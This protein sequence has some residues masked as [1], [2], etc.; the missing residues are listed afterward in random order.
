M[1]ET[2]KRI[3]EDAV[4]A[5]GARIE[6]GA[7]IERGARIESG[8]VIENGARIGSGARIESGARIGND[9]VIENDAWIASGAVIG[10]DA[11]IGRGAWIESGAVVTSNAITFNYVGSK[12]GTLTAYVDSQH[13]L[14]FTRGC[15]AGNVA[16]FLSEVQKTHGDNKYAQSYRLL[17]QA[18][19]ILLTNQ[20][21]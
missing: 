14:Y 16:S 6:S 2:A 11:Q 1:S 17:V 21:D 10:N 3:N 18:A 19:E 20:E 8:A 4:I 12:H 15:F 13:G 7:Q 9:A 5:R